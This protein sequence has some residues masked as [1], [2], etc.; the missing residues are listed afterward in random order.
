M[1]RTVTLSAD[2]AKVSGFAGVIEIAPAG[3]APV[4]APWLRNGGR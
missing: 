2:G 3:I 1:G 4:F